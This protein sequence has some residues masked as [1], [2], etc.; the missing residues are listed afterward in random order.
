[1]ATHSLHDLLSLPLHDGPISELHLTLISTY[2]LHALTVALHTTTDL[3]A[4]L[5]L[6]HD[7]TVP[8]LLSWT[9]ALSRLPEKQH[10][11]VF[12]RAY[13]VTSRFAT[14]SGT[15]PSSAYSLRTY[16]LLCLAHTRPSVIA[17]NTFWEQAT[18]FAAAF[19]KEQTVKPAEGAR[20]VL[21]G[22]ARLVACVEQR[23]DYAEF[24]A[25]PAFARFCEYWGRFAK[26]VRR[27]YVQPEA[28]L[29]S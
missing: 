1:M 7:P 24:M 25:G 19:A 28:S 26:Q 14:S 16:S 11:N 27:G 17:P 13:T 10:D 22:S 18:K 8:A 21:D 20:T 29:C 4:L 2:L 3:P 15:A 12:T 9:P 5:A 23:S 6:L